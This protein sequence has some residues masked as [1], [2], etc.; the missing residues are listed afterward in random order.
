VHTHHRVFVSNSKYMKSC[1]SSGAD[2]VRRGSDQYR[3]PCLTRKKSA[4]ES[5]TAIDLSACAAKVSD[6][7]PNVGMTPSESSAV[8]WPAIILFV[9][10]RFRLRTHKACRL[11]GHWSSEPEGSGQTKRR[12]WPGSPEG[13]PFG[14]MP[15]TPRAVLATRKC[16]FREG[17]RVAY[18]GAPSIC[19]EILL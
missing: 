10:V 11:V 7:I 19:F 13:M 9:G 15:M 1:I 8:V 3:D 16:S 2:F 18:R 4:L 12:G 14:R 5:W 6:T 17:G